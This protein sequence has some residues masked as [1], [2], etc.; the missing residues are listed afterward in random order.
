MLRNRVVDAILDIPVTLPNLLETVTENWWEHLG[1][2]YRRLIRKRHP[3]WDADILPIGDLP[4]EKM[5]RLLIEFSLVRDLMVFSYGVDK[6]IGD[7]LKERAEAAGVDWKAIEAQVK[8]ELNA[9]KPKKPA[10]KQRTGICVH[11]GC[12]NSIYDGGRFCEEHVNDGPGH[13]ER[14]E[15]PQ[16]KRGKKNAAPVDTSAGVES[17]NGVEIQLRAKAKGPVLAEIL[18][19]RAPLSKGK[20]RKAMT[21]PGWAADITIALKGEPKQAERVYDDAVQ[22]T[23]FVSSAPALF[24]AYTRIGDLAVGIGGQ[25][26]MVREWTARK[27][28]ALAA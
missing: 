23:P 22:Q 6:G 3:E 5:E 1:S 7:G 17:D 24:A 18:L 12:I 10:K 8:A 2:D 19:L 15:T 21:E 27:L 16:P 13:P 11:D 26:L 9:P 28:A 4:E 14:D 20:G 25:A